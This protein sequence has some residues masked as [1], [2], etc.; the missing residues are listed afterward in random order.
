MSGVER[1]TEKFIRSADEIEPQ[2]VL[3]F[4]FSSDNRS[5]LSSSQ[6]GGQGSSNDSVG[7]SN[8]SGGG[9]AKKKKRH[10]RDRM[11]RR[12]VEEQSKV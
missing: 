12:S 2:L 6:T 9:G 3:R 1:A 11:E 5:E 7:S 10:H 8:E 4:D